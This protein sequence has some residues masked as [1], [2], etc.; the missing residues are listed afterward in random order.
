MDDE[1][2][3]PAILAFI[4]IL[5]ETIYITINLPETFQKNHKPLQKPTQSPNRLYLVHFLFLFIFSGMEFTLTFLTFD[6]FGYTN[7][8]QGKLLA[9]MGVLTSLV[10]GGLTRYKK[11]REVL[12][13]RV[14][15][16]CCFVGLMAIAQKQEFFLYLGI[17][18]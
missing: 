10:Q 13:V 2:K 11:G 8:Q 9:M 4:L 16:G 17:E 6:L 5:I 15:L 14:G 3:A 18:F 1:F 7:R 12:M